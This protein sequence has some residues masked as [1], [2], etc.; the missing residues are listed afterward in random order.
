M[1]QDKVKAK[2]ELLKFINDNKSVKEAKNIDTYSDLLGCGNSGNGEGNGS[3][4]SNQFYD[5]NKN[6][7]EIDLNELKIVSDLIS[8]FGDKFYV[9]YFKPTENQAVTN[10]NLKVLKNSLLQHIALEESIFGKASFENFEKIIDFIKNCKTDYATQ[11]EGYIPRC[12]WDHDK[13]VPYI[14][15]AALIAG[16]TDG[17]IETAVGVF[18]IYKFTTCL[19]IRNYRAWTRE[20]FE[21]R[22]KAFAIIK[23]AYTT[24]TDLEKFTNATSGI[25]TGIKAYGV[26]TG[27]FD[28]QAR[29]NHGK[30]IF[31]VASLF[32]GVGE[33]KAILKGEKTLITV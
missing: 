17:L 9:T 31:N 1:Q 18:D 24:F 4:T 33:A 8:K 10:D 20:C 7:K 3:I 30:I 11:K 21:T 29:Y 2:Q 22:E 5:A 12:L 28:N 6:N 26:E 14:Q 27:G 25:W 15:D 13:N 32:I 16:F 19:D 23:I